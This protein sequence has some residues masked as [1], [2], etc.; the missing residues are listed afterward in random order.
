MLIEMQELIL[1]LHFFV[2][3]ITVFFNLFCLFVKFQIIEQF[4]LVLFLY[5]FVIIYL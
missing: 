2:F 3:C 5:F 1:F 4:Y